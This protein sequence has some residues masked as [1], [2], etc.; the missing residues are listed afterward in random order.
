MYKYL[1]WLAN[2]QF[3]YSIHSI[4][5]Q[6]EQTKWWKK[7]ASSPL[8]PSFSLTAK[9][10]RPTSSMDLTTK[11]STVKITKYTEKTIMLVATTILST[12][13]PIGPGEMITNSLENKIMSKEMTTLLKET[14]MS[15]VEQETLFL[16]EMPRQLNRPLFRLQFKK[17]SLKF[18]RT[19]SF[20][21]TNDA[22][23]LFYYLNFL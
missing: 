18:L 20:N 15:S 10:S 23:W 9:S 4:S 22:F 8:Q 17:K 7:C 2:L 13:I 5:K 16:A 12:V 19:G 21:S 3:L 11:S 6:S 1:I 14:E